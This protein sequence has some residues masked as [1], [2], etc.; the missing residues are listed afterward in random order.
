MRNK[1]IYL[2]PFI[3]VYKSVHFLV[4]LPFMI[5]KYCLKGIYFLIYSF[6]FFNLQVLMLFG[7]I[8]WKFIKYVSFGAAAP[9][10]YLSN[11]NM[12][13][14][15]REEKKKERQL[16]AHEKE[17][18][19]IAKKQKIKADKAAAQL[20][21]IKGKENELK[22]QEAQKELEDQVKEQQRLLQEAA[23]ENKQENILD[24]DKK[25][26]EEP[27]VT[28]PAKPLTKKE[29]KKADKL[30]KIEA[31]KKAKEEKRKFKED[32]KKEKNKLKNSYDKENTEFKKLTMGERINT[33][34]AKVIAGP[35]AY[36]K[37]SKEKIKNNALAKNARNQ[38]LM[39]KEA[40]LINFDE[41][42]EKSDKKQVYEYVGKNSEGKIVKGYFEAFS[43]VEVQSFLLSEGFEV[44][45]IKTNGFIQF[46]HGSSG[47]SKGKFKSDDLIFFLTQLSTYIKAGIP[48]VE[49]LRILSRQFKQKEYEKIFRSLI[50]ELTMGDN[51]SDAMAKQGNAFPRILVN[52]VKA[53]EMTGELPETLDDMQEYFEEID[54]TKKQ[55]ITA[56]TYPSL[57]FVLAIA[58]LSFIM[59]Y[60][61]P[62]FVGIYE[63]MDNAEL[64]FITVAVLAVSD[65][66]VQKWL[67][68]IISIVGTI[69][70]FIYLFKN[71]T[72]FKTMVQ[73]IMMKIPI[74]GEVIIFNEVTMFT[75]TFA[76]LLRHNVFITD[77]MDILN[78]ITNNEI[79]HMIILDCITNLAKGDKISTA[80]QD[81]WAVPLPAYEMIVTGER[82]GQLPEMMQKV[83]D[84]YQEMHKNQVGRIKTFVEPILIIFLTGAVGLIVMSIIIPM[85]GMYDT[86]G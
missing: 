10:V 26:E 22:E 70:I 80:F 47:G 84:Y 79:W 17:L 76:S 1:P 33:G 85:F 23:N 34:I 29:Q 83:S 36:L 38:K 69:G 9:F 44:Y 54:K 15:E 5:V 57:I 43:K 53:S 52:M 71:V 21:K 24:L 40:L 6:L 86:L 2:W 49:A 4:L 27:V 67:I 48:L 60:I 7:F 62:Q 42:S 63:D 31:K 30:A 19:A 68:L 8:W 59:V 32:L 55:M 81:H 28:E 35:S 46:L 14:E 3:L 74:I 39:E 18:A 25:P 13:S 82:T 20:A 11:I 37:K 65:F 75:K 78:K 58:A 77:S 51:F 61:V 64:P 50:Y 66:L 56:L 45:S 41:D 72:L 16:K 73:W 12:S